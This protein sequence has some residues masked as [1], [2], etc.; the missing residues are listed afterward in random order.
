MKDM[1]KEPSLKKGHYRHYKGG[2][3]NV[4]GLAC[5]SETLEWCVIYQSIER[6]QTGLPSTWVR[7]Y[8]MFIENV[9]V[10]GVTKPR[11]EKAEEE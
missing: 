3:Y 8:G 5:N 10:G 9:K 7:P 11:F 1:G 2:L 6:K 4:V